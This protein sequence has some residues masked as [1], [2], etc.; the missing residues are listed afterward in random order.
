M[1]MK[2][3][4]KAVAKVRTLYIAMLA[5]VAVRPFR[6]SCLPVW[7]EAKSL[8]VLHALHG[9]FPFLYFLEPLPWYMDSRKGAKPQ[10]QRVFEIVASLR[11]ERV[12]R[13]GVR[14]FYGSGRRHALVCMKHVGQK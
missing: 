9:I 5:K 13:V 2:D 11:L 8:H 4:K 10:R 7:P 6:L 1:S 3:M 12:K 14:H